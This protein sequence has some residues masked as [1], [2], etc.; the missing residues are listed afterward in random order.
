MLNDYMFEYRA[1]GGADQIM[2]WEGKIRPGHY[3]HI[4]LGYVKANS[5]HIYT[6]TPLEI[7]TLV[8][9]PTGAVEYLQAYLQLGLHNS[10]NI[11]TYV[12]QYDQ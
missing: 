12:A 3:L 11:D 9:F 7:Q 6:S 4:Y 1:G 8:H 2:I 5:A 10:M